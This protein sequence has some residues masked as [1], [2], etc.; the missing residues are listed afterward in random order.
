MGKRQIG[1]MQ[2]SELV[3][4]F[5]ISNIASIPIQAIEIPLVT[6]IIP[7]FT[8]AIFEIVLSQI[9]LKYP[10]TRKWILGEPSLIIKNGKVD[11]GQMKKMRINYDDIQG[12]LRTAGYPNIE[13]IKYGILETDGQL[14]IIPKQN[15]QE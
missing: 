9:S 7:V 14:S 6:G 11:I 3:V 10:K 13:D 5:M 4:A 2:P 1:E 8:L 12:E 15:S